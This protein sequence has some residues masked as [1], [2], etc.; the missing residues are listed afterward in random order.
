MRKKVDESTLHPY[1]KFLGVMSFL[2][3]FSPHLLKY[4]AQM[5][6]PPRHSALLRRDISTY[7]RCID[8]QEDEL[9]RKG[10]KVLTVQLGLTFYTEDRELDIWCHESGEWMVLFSETCRYGL[11]FY[12]YNV[13][14]PAKSHPFC[15]NF[16]IQ[17]V[18][19]QK[20]SFVSL[21]DKECHSSCHILLKKCL[22]WF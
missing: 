20:I 14:I 19:F 11:P 2:S 15:F 9:W 22:Y 8:G 18:I 21:V 12:G 16:K 10:L 6:V 5:R 17:G 13:L 4:L 1:C 3:W 7:L